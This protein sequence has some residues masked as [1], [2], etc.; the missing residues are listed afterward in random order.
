MK[1]VRRG[2]LQVEVLAKAMA[3]QILCL[4]V[5][6]EGLSPAVRTQLEQQ[7]DDAYAALGGRVRV[8]AV[9]VGGRR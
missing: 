5:F 4:P 6:L 1:A 3:T 8:H 9:Q 7:R 2:R